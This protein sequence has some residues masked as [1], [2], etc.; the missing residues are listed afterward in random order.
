MTNVW[1]PSVLMMYWVG[2]NNFKIVFKYLLNLNTSIF[3]E[4]LRYKIQ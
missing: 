3:I 2:Q 4:Y 1:E